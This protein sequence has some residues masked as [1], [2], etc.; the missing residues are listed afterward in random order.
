MIKQ[1]RVFV[2]GDIIGVGFRAWTAIQAKKLGVKGWVRN[3]FDK[4]E[5]FGV[6]GGV[7]GLLQAEE[8]ILNRMVEI[9][10]QGPAIARVEDIEI[11][12][13][14]PT[15]EFKTFEILREE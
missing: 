14:I 10:K 2:K 1:A 9:L 4:P 6:S 13:E 5:I 15:E 8:K 7:E 12:Y 3:V 11:D